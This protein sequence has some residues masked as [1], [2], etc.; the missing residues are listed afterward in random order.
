MATRRVEFAQFLHAPRNVPATLL[1]SLELLGCACKPLRG[2]HQPCPGKPCFSRRK[3]DAEKASLCN[4]SHQQLQLSLFERY[5][6]PN[7]AGNDDQLYS[8]SYLPLTESLMHPIE[9][10][11]EQSNKVE[12]QKKISERPCGPAATRA[13]A[14]MVSR[15]KANVLLR[16]PVVSAAFLVLMIVVGPSFSRFLLN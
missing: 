9:R 5:V 3:R 2:A 4:E 12:S 13:A 14:P 1:N 10:V 6:R 7:I 8:C 15:G 11:V 16:N